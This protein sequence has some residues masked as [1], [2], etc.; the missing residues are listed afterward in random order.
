MGNRIC[1]LFLAFTIMLSL[2][3]CQGSFGK[4]NLQEAITIPEDGII[5]QS[6]I[7]QIKNENAIGSFVGES[8]GF[9]YEWTIFGSDIKD[10]K[11]INLLAAVSE[12]V[13]GDIKISMTQG[14]SFGFSG[15][16]S[17][18]LNEAWEAQSATAYQG[19][20][21]V[22]SV[23][24]TGSK[25][26]IL[27]ISTDGSL[28]EF[29][30][31][32]DALPEDAATAPDEA[33]EPSTEETQGTV[34]KDVYLSDSKQSDDTVYTDGKDKYLTDPIP[35][36]KPKPVEPEDQAVDKETALTCSFSIEC[37]TILN[38]LEQLDPDKLE[39]V[40]SNGV[41]LAKTTVTFYEG[42]SVFD[43]LQRVCK[44][45]GIH[46][47]ASWTPIYNSAYIEGIHNLYEFDCGEL[48]GW[49]YRV[50]G[51]YPNYGCSRYQLKDGDVVEWRFTCDL[52][53]DVG[54]SGSW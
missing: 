16:L 15:L 37:S 2:C 39:T 50:N 9:K 11:E 13:T 21:A 34:G 24:I 44:E 22:A 51:W 35:E 25:Q 40:P 1:S 46:M 14:E 17:V 48:S 52:G 8:N 6:T 7:E 29:V 31:C 49:M 53:N 12:T 20:S 54:R 45:Y 23:S 30:I 32:P 36:G 10:A 18:Y 26:T 5:K 43:V 27:N 42:E 47:E 28:G 41:I 19:G 3:A 33:T 38:N 4:V